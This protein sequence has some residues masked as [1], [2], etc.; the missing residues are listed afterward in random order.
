[1]SFD[2]NYFNTYLDNGKKTAEIKAK[3]VEFAQTH[4]NMADIDNYIDNLFIKA[5]GEPAFKKVPGYH[6]AT[7][8]SVND[9]FVHGIPKGMLHPGDLVT[10]D[11]GMFYKGT[12]SDTAISF[13]IGT[14]TP[15]QQHFLD[16]G[17]KTLKK[18]IEK[19]KAGNR[20]RDIAETIQKNI[21]GAGY[22]VTRNLTGHGVGY[23]MHEDPPIPCFVSNDPCLR[24]RIEV[25]MVLAIEIMYMKGDWPLVQASNGWNLSTKDGQDSAVFEEDVFITP[26]GPVVLTEIK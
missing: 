25:G 9:G 1:M 18:T 6:W 5:G 10:I 3:A 7:C 16:V 4:L 14:P 20:I 23:T 15:E 13:V 19:A 8:I 22:N 24:T 11:M 26:T 17:Q 21:E 12:T 2:K